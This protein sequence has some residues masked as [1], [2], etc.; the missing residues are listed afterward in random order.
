MAA[1]GKLSTFRLPPLPSIREIIKL[2]RLQAA[3]Q[4]SQNFLLDLRLTDKIVRKA[5][6]LT[7]AYVYEVGPGPGGITRSI[8]N[9][10]VAELLVVEKD[11]RFIPGLQMLSDA[12]PGKLRIVHGDVLTFKV[13]KAFPESLKRPW[14]DDP[15]N[16]H[17]IGNLPFSVST[18]LII[19]WLESMSCRDGPFVYGRTQMTLTF[20]KEVAE[21]L[22]ATT[23]SKQRSRLSIMAQYLCNVRHIFTIPGR[24]FVPKPE[25]DVGVVHFTPLI[26]PK[27]EQP[28]KLVEKV[29][30]NVF[31]F[32]RKYCHRGLGMLFPEAQR[33][34]S[35]GRLLELADVDP[36]LRPCQLSIPQF[37]SLCDVYRRMCDEDPH[38]F[39]Y[40]FRE[41]LKQRKSEKKEKEEDE[42]SHRL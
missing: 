1:S 32:R 31:Q 25:V 9:A 27:I 12:A 3:K 19:K 11:T 16:V 21:R 17:I 7:D 28:F 24:A 15:P 2:F 4:L 37:K 38:L 33:L 23:G 10:S 8:L 13:E 6:N 22:A 35:T 36:T 39:A 5:G 42:E 18:P 14:E 40:N 30:Q 26:H 20:Q 34:E 41:E 29:V